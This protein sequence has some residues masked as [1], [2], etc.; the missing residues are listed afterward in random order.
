MDRV[1]GVG[2]GTVYLPLSCLQAHRLRYVYVFL[3]K[4]PENARSPIILLLFYDYLYSVVI[5][6]PW[7]YDYKTLYLMLKLE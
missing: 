3:A 5:I 6:E 4:Q 7:V 1:G 2:A